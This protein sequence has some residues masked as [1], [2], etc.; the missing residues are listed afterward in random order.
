MHFR[1]FCHKLWFRSISTVLKNLKRSFFSS[2]DIWKFFL[3]VRQCLTPGYGN[4]FAH[5]WTRC[6]SIKFHIFSRSGN[7]IFGNIKCLKIIPLMWNSLITKISTWRSLECPAQTFKFYLQGNLNI[8]FLSEIVSV[9]KIHA[10][11]R[12]LDTIYF[13]WHT[14]KSKTRVTLHSTLSLYI[15]WPMQYHLCNL[16][17]ISIT[18]T[19]S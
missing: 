1:I 3:S 18:C 4:G 6:F 8:W 2:F 9:F 12:Y 14:F 11:I 13:Q 17:R 16:L 19:I 7:V 15:P 10:F 5:T